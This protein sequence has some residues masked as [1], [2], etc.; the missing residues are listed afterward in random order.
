MNIGWRA[1]LVKPIFKYNITKQMS[2]IM[3]TI[4][5]IN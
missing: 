2:E 4:I 5:I 1:I 3:I